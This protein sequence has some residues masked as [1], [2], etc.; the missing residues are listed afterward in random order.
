MYVL[1]ARS[2]SDTWWIS[3]RGY[4]S[5]G[6]SVRNSQLSDSSSLDINEKTILFYVQIVCKSIIN[7]SLTR[8]FYFL[9]F[10]HMYR[11]L[12]IR[13]RCHFFKWNCVRKIQS[14]LQVPSYLSMKIM[15]PAGYIS[16]CEEISHKIMTLRG[17]KTKIHSSWSWLLLTRFKAFHVCKSI[18]KT[19]K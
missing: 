4:E 11:C 9:L 10:I 19:F 2:F 3:W 17:I 12:A 18:R 5:I 15:K 1:P 7:S 8:P 14:T 16:T 6:K 13:C